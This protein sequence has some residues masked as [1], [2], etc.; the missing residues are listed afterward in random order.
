MM[1]YIQLNDQS[2]F[3]T[4][5]T[6]PEV[7]NGFE[8]MDSASKMPPFYLCQYLNVICIHLENTNQCLTVCLL[9][10]LT[11]LHTAAL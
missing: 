8:L 3:Q 1:E 4:K 10:F 6:D 5:K 11:F 9:D 7:E 2:E